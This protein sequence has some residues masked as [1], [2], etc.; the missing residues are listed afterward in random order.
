MAETTEKK[1]ILLVD[2]DETHLLIA[3]SMLKHDYHTIVAKSGQ[4]ALDVFTQGN[5]PDLVLLDI[6]MPNMDGW[7][8]YHSIR[9]LS[10][11]KDVPIAF[12]TSETDAAEEKKAYAMGASDYILKPYD[13]TD[14]LKRIKIILQKKA[15]PDSGVESTH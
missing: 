10:L 9:G 13:K 15:V 8:T 3:Q 6:L 1:I 7:A 2:D 12:L 11:L 14:L 4:E 5:N